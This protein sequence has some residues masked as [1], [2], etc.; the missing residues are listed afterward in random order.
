MFKDHAFLMQELKDYASPRAKLTR[1]I[2]SGEIIQVRRGLFL[3]AS[4]KG[5]S[6]KS[7]AAIIYGP[8]YISFESAASYHGLI[9]ERVSA[10][11]SAT[12]KK[13]KNRSF[14][15]PFGDFFYYYLPAAVYPHSVSCAQE[16]GMNFLI[17]SP[18]KALCDMIY[19]TGKVCRREA[20]RQLLFEDWR[21]EPE[22]LTE[23]DFEVFRFIAPLYRK[24][25]F[26][27]LLSLLAEERS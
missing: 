11:T 6:L 9:P 18:E 20:M 24:R 3:A 19:R 13:N 23:L 16:N 12:Y 17:A 15:T 8:S 26:S 4:E 1:M 14:H 10:I 22:K 21:I 7:L 27:C 5:Y 25:V 2:K